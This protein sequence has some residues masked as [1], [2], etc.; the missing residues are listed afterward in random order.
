MTNMEI[1]L[2]AASASKAARQKLEENVA[3]LESALQDMA[4]AY[5]QGVQDA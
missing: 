3:M 4:A 1:M 2:T 5:E